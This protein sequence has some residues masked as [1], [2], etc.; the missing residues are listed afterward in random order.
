[1]SVSVCRRSS[2]RVRPQ[3][4][5]PGP[6]TVLKGLCR[7]EGLGINLTKILA[8]IPRVPSEPTISC[9]RLYPVTSFIRLPPSW[10]ILSVGVTISSPWMYCPVT[11]YLTALPP[12]AFLATLPPMKQN[13]SLLWLSRGY[14]L[15]ICGLCLRIS[16]FNPSKAR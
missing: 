11:L 16:G 13:S 14:P 5:F 1:M 6:R 9:T 7:T 2:L 12:P 8:K 10:T 4:P 3:W 15:Q